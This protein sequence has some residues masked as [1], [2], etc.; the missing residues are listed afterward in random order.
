MFQDSKNVGS[1]RLVARIEP[2]FP[3]IVVAPSGKMLIEMQRAGLEA[4]RIRSDLLASTRAYI[5]ERMSL[6]TRDASLRLA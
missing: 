5:G 3:A 6:G 1:A 4:G 2:G